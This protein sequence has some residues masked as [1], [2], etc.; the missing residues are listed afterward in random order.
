MIH[1]N[2]NVLIMKILKKIEKTIRYPKNID[3]IFVNMQKT[4]R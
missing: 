3:K 2:L 4:N 1:F